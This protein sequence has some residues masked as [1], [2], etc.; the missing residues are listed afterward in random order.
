M[1]TEPLSQQIL[2]AI[3]LFAVLIALYLLPA[4]AEIAARFRTWKAACKRRMNSRLHKA[5]SA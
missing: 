1:H 3:G 5:K 2:V 4:N